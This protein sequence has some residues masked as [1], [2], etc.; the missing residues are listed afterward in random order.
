MPRLSEVDEGARVRVVET[1]GGGVEGMLRSM[2]IIP[3]AVI[4]VVSNSKH[5]P[6]SPLIVEARGLRVAVGRDVARLITVSILN[7]D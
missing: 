2:G 5:I 1:P 7:E 4:T 6:W 3:G